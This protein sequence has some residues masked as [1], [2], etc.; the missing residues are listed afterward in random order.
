MADN[1]VR[2]TVTNFDK[3]P[4][5]QFYDVGDI[6]ILKRGTIY[7]CTLLNNKK[8]FIQFASI[9]SVNNAVNRIIKLENTVADHEARIKALE[10]P[11]K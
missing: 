5:V 9:I 3:L 2:K 11:T 8:I 4:D 6:V 1:F 7:M 10:T